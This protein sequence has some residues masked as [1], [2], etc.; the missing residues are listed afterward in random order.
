MTAAAATDQ[1][2][3]ERLVCEALAPCSNDLH[4]RLAE[5]LL[6][7][8]G[9]RPSP[10][11]PRVGVASA[12]GRG[13]IRAMCRDGHIWIDRDA[14]LLVEKRL[15]ETANPSRSK[16]GAGKD[17][18]QARDPAGEAADMQDAAVRIE[19]LREHARVLVDSAEQA[20]LGVGQ[21]KPVL[22]HGGLRRRR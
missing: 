7:G 15:G 17:L 5:S 4:G 16:L 14:W 9:G 1:F 19:L 8:G 22:H 11:T 6:P 21:H 10:A 18:P 13:V 3:G 20:L 2:K 12:E